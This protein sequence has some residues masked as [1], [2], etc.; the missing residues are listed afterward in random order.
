M[1]SL[2]AAMT[3]S[4]VIGK[5]GM[6][7]WHLPADFAWF[8]RQTLGKPV[9]MGRKTWES[10][11]RPLPGR[12]N[13]V[14][15]R[16]AGLQLPGVEVV[17]TPEQAVLLAADAPEIMVIGGAQLYGHFLPQADRLYLTFVDATL[18]GDAWFPD[19]TQQPWL[20]LE[21]HPHPADDKN[22]YPCSFHIFGRP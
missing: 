19:Y 18:D 22:P 8:R 15:S 11:G 5:D 14:V 10:I 3:P 2:I 21:S 20:L 1:L 16:T 12:R 13:I 17:P 9:I 6:M 4:R 7:P